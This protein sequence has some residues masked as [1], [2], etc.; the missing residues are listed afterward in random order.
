MIRQID[1]E[2]T[3]MTAR[4]PITWTDNGRMALLAKLYERAKHQ[5]NSRPP[6]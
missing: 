6:K 5:E 2:R 3:L 4:L 1:L